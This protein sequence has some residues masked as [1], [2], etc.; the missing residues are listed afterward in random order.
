MLIA[1]RAFCTHALNAP[2]VATSPYTVDARRWAPLRRYLWRLHCTGRGSVVPYDD[3]EAMYLRWS[4]SSRRSLRD[5]RLARNTFMQLEIVADRSAAAL[6]A[7][8]NDV[9]ALMPNYT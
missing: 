6:M 8:I 4:P 5:R 2:G 1:T 9:E 7:T 3:V